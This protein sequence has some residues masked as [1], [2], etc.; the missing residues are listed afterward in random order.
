MEDPLQVQSEEHKVKTAIPADGDLE[1]FNG[2]FLLT[3]S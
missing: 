2:T 1:N 3:T